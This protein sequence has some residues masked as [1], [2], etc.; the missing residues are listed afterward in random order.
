MLPS[1]P[2]PH[3]HPI[4]VEF[5]KRRITPDEFDDP[6]TTACGLPLTKRDVEL[7]LG[8]PIV[9]FDL[10]K[11]AFTQKS[12]CGTVEH[13]ESY[14][15]MEFIGDSV[16][17]FIVT[18]YL[19]DSFPGRDEGF[20]TRLRT[21]MV[22]GKFLSVVSW[23]LGLHRLVIMNQKGLSRGWNANHRIL[24]DV[25]EAVIGAVYLDQG[26]IA[27]RDFVMSAFSKHADLDTVMIDTNHKDR[28]T[29]HLKRAGMD[30]GSIEF[31]TV[32]G[33]GGTAAW[34][35]VEVWVNGAVLG[36]GE[37]KTKRDAEQ[38]ASKNALLGMGV[39]DE[40]IEESSKPRKNKSSS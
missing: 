15:R 22:S 10:Y 24:E 16:L 2:P 4:D 36:R 23:R 8:F 35:V 14:E 31:K 6:P 34:F 32:H 11:T 21:K 12:A 37:A 7:T 30:V 25:L 1:C 5:A 17:N 18:K 40:Y 39:S 3:G 20:L 19:Y 38:M 33:Q 29:K 13:P 27:A 28:L 26:M 9:S